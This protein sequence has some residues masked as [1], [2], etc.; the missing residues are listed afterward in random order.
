M[1]AENFLQ[2]DMKI[3]PVANDSSNVY[4]FIVILKN[5]GQEISRTDNQYQFKDEKWKLLKNK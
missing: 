4:T 3:F 5:E 1:I 2:L